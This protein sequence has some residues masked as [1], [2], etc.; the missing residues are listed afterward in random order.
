MNEKATVTYRV[1]ESQ[2][3]PGDWVAGAADRAHEGA[4]Y[5]VVFIGP[6]AQERAEEYAAWKNAARGLAA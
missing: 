3:F 2:D 5:T 4:I 1:F 6:A